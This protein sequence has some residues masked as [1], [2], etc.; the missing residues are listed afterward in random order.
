MGAT[1]AQALE[2]FADEWSFLLWQFGVP[3]FQPP[4]P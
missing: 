3:E 4:K 2:Q 1:R